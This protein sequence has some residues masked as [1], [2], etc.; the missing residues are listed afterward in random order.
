MEYY[1]VDTLSDIAK[2]SSSILDISISKSVAKEVVGRSRGTPRIANALLRRGDFA[3]VKG[4]GSITLDITHLAL[5]A[6]NVD[7]H[8][9]DDMATES[10]RPL[11]KSLRVV[12]WTYYHSHCGGRA[13]RH[14]R[15]GL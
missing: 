6:L 7:A 12:Q 3:Q 5:E 13:K 1:N 2:R 14:H 11:L 8:G 9:L 10:Y 4:D 15:R